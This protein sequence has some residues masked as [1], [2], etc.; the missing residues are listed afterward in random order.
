MAESAVGGGFCIDL[1][2]KK[3]VLLARAAR[4]Q[5]DYLDASNHCWCTQT[6]AALGP[7]GEPA[8]PADCGPSR[9]CFRSVRPP[10]HPPATKD[11]T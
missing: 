2:S 6:G 11:R 3:F 8:H 4:S 1:R 7:D 9:A 10:I 5:E